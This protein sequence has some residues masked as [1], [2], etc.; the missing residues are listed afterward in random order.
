MVQVHNSLQFQLHPTIFWSLAAEIEQV[1]YLVLQTG[2]EE[3]PIP[4]PAPHPGPVPAGCNYPQTV[5][6]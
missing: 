3:T 6:S 1:I 5:A 2:R 4:C